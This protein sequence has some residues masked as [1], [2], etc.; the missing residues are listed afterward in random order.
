MKPKQRRDQIQKGRRID[1]A[2]SLK[3]TATMKVAARAVPLNSQPVIQRLKWKLGLFAHFQLH[4][5]QPALSGRRQKVYEGP[6]LASIRRDL[7]I[8][9]TR[10]ERRIQGG[11]IAP[12]DGFEPA[13]GLKA[14]HHLIPKFGFRAAAGYRLLNKPLQLVLVAGIELQS[15]FANSELD[16][17][18]INPHPR[19]FKTAN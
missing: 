1:Q 8:N 12:D 5:H 13:L 10:I 15:R 4:H 16:P 6:L 18:A 11:H 19:D 9:K 14:K 7:R 2:Q 3:V 17:A